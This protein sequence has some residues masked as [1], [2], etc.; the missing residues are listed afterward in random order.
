MSAPIKV[1]TG[2]KYARL[3]SVA[4][5]RG[6]RV[7]DNAE[8]CTYIDSS[9]E[10][11]QQRTGIA[12]RRWA[13][14][15]ETPAFMCVQAATKAIERAGLGASDIDAVIVSTVSNFRQYPS[16]ACEVA[17][18][19]GIPAPAAYDIRAACAGFCYALSQADGLIRTGSAHHVLIIGMELLSKQIDLTDRG[20][21]FLFGDGAG[22]AVVGPSETPAIGPAVWGS[23]PSQDD[24]IWTEDWFDALG[25]GRP[26]VV[27]MNGRAVYLWGTTFIAEKAV[28]ALDKAGLAPEQLDVFIPHQAN[29][30]ITDAL[31]RRLHLPETVTV[32]RDIRH[33]GNVSAASIPL[34]MDALLESGE[35]KSGDNALIIGFGAGLVFA[36]QVVVLP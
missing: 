10:W 14:E 12:E 5:Y 4:G 36:G 31:L 23:D 16:L 26:P 15:E 3:M 2:A 28:E 34:A 6:S 30:R 22:A 20:T 8:M 11:I 13:T 24:A 33:M 19:L 9:D 25:T 29:N 21:A 32:S 17:R 18:A 7:V 27:H 35:A 1:S